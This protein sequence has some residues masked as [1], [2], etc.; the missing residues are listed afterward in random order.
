MK[1]ATY[2]NHTKRQVLAKSLL[3]TINLHPTGSI[4]MIKTL[5][6]RILVGTLWATTLALSSVKATPVTVQE[7][8]ISPYEIVSI[9][10]PIPYVGGVYAGVNHL[11]VNG[12]LN[13]GFCIDPFHF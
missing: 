9:I 10:V 6:K 7:I 13:N 4:A 5:L 8:G 1:G 11:L 3:T 2:K 12:V